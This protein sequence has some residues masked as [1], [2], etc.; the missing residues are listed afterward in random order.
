MTEL[1]EY[2]VGKHLR[3]KIL[4]HGD[5]PYM[6][7]IEKAFTPFTMSRV[8]GLFENPER[9]TEGNGSQV[10]QPPTLSGRAQ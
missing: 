6:A 1:T 9:D 2:E 3:I 8:S 5:D 4:D 7:T 10:I